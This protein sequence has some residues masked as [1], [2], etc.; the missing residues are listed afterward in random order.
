[1]SLLAVFVVSGQVPKQ[2][3]FLILYPQMK[4]RMF[5]EKMGTAPK[6]LEL[7]V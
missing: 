2:N 5:N 3:L 6:T 7:L 4:I 1:M